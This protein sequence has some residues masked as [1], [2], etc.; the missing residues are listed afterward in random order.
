M[1]SKKILIIDDEDN[2]R[3][4][5]T[6]V[7]ERENYM[8]ISS[9]DTDDGYA[10]VLKSKPDLLILDVKVPRIGG[11]ELCRLLRENQ[12]TKHIP[13]IM[14]TVESTET[15]KV[16]GL[17]AGAD[18][19]VTKPFSNKELLAR[20]ASLL[21]RVKR[22]GEGDDV[23]KSANIEVN[24]KSHSVTLDGR[25]LKLRP[26][27]FDLL[28]LFLRNPNVVFDRTYILENV[29]GYKI[30]VST[31]TIDTHIKNL[32]H[33]L[34]SFGEKIQTIFGRGFKFVP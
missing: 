31:R 17:E 22:S 28:V 21:R 18:D 7:L 8:V 5:V 24:I 16:I 2:I 26:K 23:I 1:I 25:D 4:L 12:D 19:Y 29:F 30:P 15:D 32:R 14:L 10:R 11:I 13:I 3:S 34:G 33:S 9:P 6:D 20:V 27:E